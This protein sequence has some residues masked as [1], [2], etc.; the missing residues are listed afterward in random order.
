MSVF[1]HYYMYNIVINIEEQKSYFINLKVAHLYNLFVHQMLHIFIQK[2]Q[3]LTA[4]VKSSTLEQKDKN[5]N[6]KSSYPAEEHFQH[7]N[8]HF[9]SSSHGIIK[10]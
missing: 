1:T 10:S 8:N 9:S 3:K 6:S 7:S 5:C 2:L 4:P